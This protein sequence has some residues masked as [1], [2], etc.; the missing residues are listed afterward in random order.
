MFIFPGGD[1]KENVKKIKGDT[2]REGY[3]AKDGGA[4]ILMW[5]EAT[6]GMITWPGHSG[7]GAQ[8]ILEL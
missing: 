6:L 4:S 8:E 1:E 5:P 3:K 2:G 7:H